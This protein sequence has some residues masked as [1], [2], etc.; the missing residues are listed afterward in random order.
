MPV[1][2]SVHPLWLVLAAA[3]Q[4][5][6]FF[7][8]ADAQAIDVKFTVDERLPVLTVNGRFLS[9]DRANKR[10]LNFARD[11]A[12]T[13]GLAERISDLT[14]AA[15]DAGEVKYKRLMAG[16]YL[17]DGQFTNWNYTTAL[18]PVGRPSTM[19]H[20]SWIDGSSGILF[21][22]DILPQVYGTDRSALVTIDVPDGWHILTVERRKTGD[23]FQVADVERAVFVLSKTDAVRKLTTGSITL[24]IFG[25]WQ[26]SDAEASAQASE[27]LKI[28]DKLF[29]TTAS[30]TQVTIMRMP[31]EVPFGIWEADT[32]GMSVTILS[33]DMPFKAPST[34]RL[35]EQL[36]HEFFHLWFPN[37]VELTG[38]YDWF[39]EGFALY[40]SLKIGIG[41]NRI[42]FDDFLDS[43]AQA[44]RVDALQLDRRSL[45]AASELRWSGNGVTVYSR[46]MLVALLCDL[47]ILRASGGKQSVDDLVRDIYEQALTQ[48]TVNG[49]DVIISAMRAR[50]ELALIFDKYITG[51]QPI[52]WRAELLAAGIVAAGEGPAVR[53]SVVPKPNRQQKDLLDRLG[54]NNWRKLSQSLK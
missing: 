49:N 27:I 21:L 29:R 5:L 11:H 20:V 31:K 44:Y 13:I 8:N 45:I 33:S 23:T 6:Q 9:S 14:L 53:L 28:Y 10:N 12:G 16:E 50:S 2:K 39:Y 19:A 30:A 46:G 1:S 35:H 51:T 34:Q 22:D 25:E 42:R 26:F 32:R 43:L 52:D 47:A 37:G 15:G 40:E 18:K 7:T 48:K 36:R 4:I 54:Y 17:A 41:S 24:N 38:R 3:L